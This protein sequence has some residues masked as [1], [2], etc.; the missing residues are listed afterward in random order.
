VPGSFR[1]LRPSIAFFVCQ[2]QSPDFLRHYHQRSN[3]ESAFSMVKRKYGDAVRSKTDVSMANEVLCK[4]VCH[5]LCVLI[6]EMYELGI[7]PGLGGVRPDGVEEDELRVIR[8]RGWGET[9]R[10]Y[11]ADE[12][13]CL[14]QTRYANTI[15]GIVACLPVGAGEK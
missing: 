2:S 8:I 6:A 4:L 3:I 11:S 7:D 1:P 14:M 9:T 10:W 12:T 15:I 5:N 13:V